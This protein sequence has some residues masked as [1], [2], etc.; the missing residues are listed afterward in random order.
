M[1]QATAWLWIS[2]WIFTIFLMGRPASPTWLT[3]TSLPPPPCC[4]GTMLLLL[5]DTQTQPSSSRPYIGPQKGT[6]SCCHSQELSNKIPRHLRVL[7]WPGFGPFLSSWRHPHAPSRGCVGPSQSEPCQG[8][9]GRW[10]EGLQTAVFPGWQ[11]L[12]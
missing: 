12:C 2:A 11:R 6:G 7:G 8:W 10:G 3:T 4:L 5:G 9:A 1:A